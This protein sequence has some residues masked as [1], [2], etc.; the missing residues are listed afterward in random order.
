MVSAGDTDISLHIPPGG[1][2]GQVKREKSLKCQ[3][4]SKLQFG[5]GGAGGGW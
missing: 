3:D 2:S 1:Y 4:L 5:E